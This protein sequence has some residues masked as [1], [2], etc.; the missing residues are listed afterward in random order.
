MKMKILITGSSGLIGTSVCRKMFERGFEPITMDLRQSPDPD[1]QP[2]F[3][4]INDPNEV[5]KA[6]KDVQGVIHLAAISRVIDGEKYPSLCRKT[7]IYGSENIFK[8]ATESSLHPWV[9]Y[10]SSRE[11]YGEPETIPVY[12]THPVNAINVYGETKVHTEN[13][14]RSSRGIN[15]IIFRYSNVYGSVYDHKTRVIPAFMR[16]ALL[17]Q[18]LRVDC[19]NHVFDFTYVQD[20]AE[21]TVRGAEALINDRIQGCTT[22]NVSPGIGTSLT[23]LVNIVA[24]VTGKEV[25]TVPGIKRDY[26]VGQYIG[27]SSH[28][29][30]VLGYQCQTSLL[31]GLQLLY[32]DYLAS[33]E[34]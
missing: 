5:K 18:P 8:A 26:D 19:P 4:D 2:Q 30:K 20:V 10:G 3:T 21:A 7:N 12:E 6:I 34:V 23:E 9:I 29:K 25:T 24:G 15:S 32:E 33:K 14:L 11:I 1:F 13:N 27:D 16:G 22:F 31:K 28:L 17:D